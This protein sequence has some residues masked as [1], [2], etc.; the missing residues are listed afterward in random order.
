MHVK[1]YDVEFALVAMQF[2]QQQI[3]DE[4][5]THREECVY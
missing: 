2:T 4:H 5:S 3:G 1:Q